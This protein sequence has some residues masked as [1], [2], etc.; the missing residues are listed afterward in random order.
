M[1]QAAAHNL[2]VAVGELGLFYVQGYGTGPDPAKGVALLRQADKAGD[3]LA[4][5]NLAVME[6]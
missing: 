6:M 5:T 3:D 2:P 4:T 1:S